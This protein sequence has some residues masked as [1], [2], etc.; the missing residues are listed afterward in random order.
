MTRAELLARLQALPPLAGLPLGRA[1]IEPLPGL[2]NRSYKIT[3][4]GQR[5]VL[6]LPGVGTERYID[7]RQEAH[8]RAVAAE[9]GVAPSLLYGDDDG[10]QLTRFIDHA[11][12][13]DGAALRHNPAQLRAVADLLRRLHHS[14]RAFRGR[15]VLFPTLDRYLGLAPEPEL[16]GL[17][18]G[19]EPLRAG[20]EAG[21]QPLCPCHVDPAPANF[22]A[23]PGRLYLLDWEYAAMCEPLWDL[24]GLAMEADLAAAGE[25]QL[26]S[27]YCG[28]PGAAVYERF[29]HYK[30]LLNLLA[31]A[32]AAVQIAAGKSGHDYRALITARAATARALLADLSAT[33]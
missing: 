26:L 13:L 3:V 21:A 7:R 12:P 33:A 1:K 2:T 9:L 15:V 28:R 24:A 14:G 27:A 6:R 19:V 17:R 25:H 11:E 32:W 29:A 5:Y 23:A 4:A 30:L 31:G 20:F 16:L 8:N 18:R 10:V 22:L